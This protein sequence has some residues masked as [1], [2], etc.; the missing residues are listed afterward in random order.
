VCTDRAVPQLVSLMDSDGTNDVRVCV[1]AD[2]LE[3]AA[4][5]TYYSVRL[6]Q[7]LAAG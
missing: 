7:V 2:K 3:L 4:K 1:R 6:L 5:L